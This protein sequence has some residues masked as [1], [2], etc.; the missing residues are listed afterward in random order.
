L[1]DFGLELNDEFIGKHE[2]IPFTK[3]N[4]KTR[5]SA[6]KLIFQIVFTRNN[7]AL[8]SPRFSHLLLRYQLIPDVRMFG[9][10]NLA[11]ES[12]ELGDLGFTD[13]FSVAS[14]Y[15]PPSF[16]H[17]NNEDFL[18]RMTDMKR[19][20]VTRLERN[21]VNEILLSHR[22]MARLLIPGTDSLITF[23]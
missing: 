22:V 4:I 2:H 21:A 19:F 7:T 1:K 9:D 13:S 5:L 17:L 14:I 6:N 15:V 16:D 11:E 18:I 12:F 20:K 3:E 10:M 23:P 8:P